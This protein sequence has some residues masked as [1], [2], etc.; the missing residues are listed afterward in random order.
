MLATGYA[1]A[2]GGWK[3]KR[4]NISFCEHDDLKTLDNLEECLKKYTYTFNES[5][6]FCTKPFK[7]DFQVAKGGLLHF[8]EPLGSLLDP[9]KNIVFEIGLNPTLNYFV[10]FFDPKFKFPSSNPS[11]VPYVLQK[12]DISSGAHIFY[13]K[14]RCIN[15]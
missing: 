12:I 9:S 1:T 15:V 3:V 11:A 10:A 8:M 2:N 13:L 5:V 14:V 6:T 4:K 7:R